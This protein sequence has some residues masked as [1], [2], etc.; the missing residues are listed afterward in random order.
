MTV[1]TNIY[2]LQ[3]NSDTVNYLPYH[4]TYIFGAY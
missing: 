4:S 3:L 1:K 2:Y